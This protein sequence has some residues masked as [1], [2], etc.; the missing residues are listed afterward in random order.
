MTSNQ[1]YSKHFLP[2]TKQSFNSSPAKKNNFTSLEPSFKNNLINKGNQIS[3]E[4]DNFN[5]LKDIQKSKNEK[6]FNLRTSTNEMQNS[7]SSNNS[8]EDIENPLNCSERKTNFLMTNFFCNSKNVPPDMD[9]IL[10]TNLNY[11]ISPLNKNYNLSNKIESSVFIK[12]EWFDHNKSESCSS[13]EE[14]KTFKEDYF[15]ETFLE[16]ESSVNNSDNNIIF[17]DSDENIESKINNNNNLPF[18][19]FNDNVNSVKSNDYY[20]NDCFNNYLNNSLNDNNNNLNNLNILNSINNT[21]LWQNI[22]NNFNVNDNKMQKNNCNNLNSYRN[23]NHIYNNF[24]NQNNKNTDK[25]QNNNFKNNNSDYKNQINQN[26]NLI[27]LIN[28]I[29][30]NSNKTNIKNIFNKNNSNQNYFL[31]NDA[32]NITNTRPKKTKSS[33]YNRISNIIK[34]PNNFSYCMGNLYK[35]DSEQIINETYNLTKDQ[36]GCRFLQKKIE[37][38][39][40]FAIAKIFP[41]ILEHLNEIITDK[42]GNYLIQKFFEYLSQDEIYLFLNKIKNNFLEISL[43]QY[44]TRVIQK[45]IDYIKSDANEPSVKNYNYFINILT[46]HITRL[47][48]DLNGCHIIQKILLTKNFDN[49][50]CYNYYKEHIIEIANDKNGCCFLQKCIDKLNGESLNLIFDFIFNKKCELV[51]DQYGNYVIQYVLRTLN[52]NEKYNLCEIFSFMVDD[53]VKYSNQKFCSNVIE[54]LF[55]I[56]K[57]RNEIINKLYEP[58]IMRALLF[59]QYGNYVVQKALVNANNDELIKLLTL[60]ATMIDELKKKDFGF[61]LYQKLISKYPIL[62]SIIFTV[63]NNSNTTGVKES[64]Y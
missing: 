40:K 25:Y 15:K 12:D 53:L 50:F 44:G 57:L 38:D 46:P 42:F 7:F 31:N 56:E 39:T 34:Y 49:F 14:S 47:S 32:N 45:L 52:Y 54:K 18:F 2:I 35:M 26:S 33:K 58:N 41:I 64:N 43:N 3:N 63:H 27:N 60:I 62:L 36:I 4:E 28:S 5:L 17:K 23:N 59:N 30:L 61:K 48:N 20:L 16:E 22:V 9:N 1:L 10:D 29:N 6:I 37:E 13:K 55:N 19:S 21:I 24:D 8:K 51:I 11:S